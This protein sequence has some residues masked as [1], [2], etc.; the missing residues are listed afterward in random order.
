[1][2]SFWK[3][4]APRASMVAGL[5]EKN[6]D[7][8]LWLRPSAISWKISGSESES[9]RS[10]VRFRADGVAEV[11]TNEVRDKLDSRSITTGAT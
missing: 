9:N 8:S 2:S 6:L 3:M 4:S 5:V 7:V 11:A 10:A 1:M